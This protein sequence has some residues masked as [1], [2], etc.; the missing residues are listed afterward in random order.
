MTAAPARFLTALEHQPI[1]ITAEG[2]GGSL[3]PAEAESLA[4]I[5]ELRRGFCELGHRKLKLAQYC[6]VVSL[7]GRVLEV[8]PK[9]QGG[10]E[11]AE[12]CR[13][14]L[15][16][17]LKLTD[18]F[19]QFQHLPAGQHLR[20]APL[21]EAFISA[22]F[23]SV[24]SVL[25]GG[26]LRQYQEHEED[27]QIVR[28]RIVVGRQMGVHA[29][30]PDL[31][32]C[33][34]DELTADNVWNRVLKKAIRVT[35]PWIRSVELNRR[36]VELLGVLDEVND[37]HLAPLEVARLNFDRR[38]ERYRTA[39]DWA[40][41]ILALLTPALRAG[42]NEAPALLFDMNKLFESAVANTLRRQAG[43]DPGLQV[44]TQNSTH[45][46]ATVAAA[47][48]EGPSFALRP[49]LVLQRGSEVVAIADT[50]WKLLELDREG[51][52]VPSEADMYQM[53]AYATAFRCSELA[54]IYPRHD[55]ITAAVDTEFR[56]PPVNVNGTS[57]TV[58]VLGVDVDDDRLPLRMGD[59]SGLVGRLLLRHSS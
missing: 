15:L 30:R 48:R 58:R 26:L 41:W 14:V 12:Q 4:Q 38:A 29:N 1:P 31:V 9:T 52:Q 44:L 25:R 18:R 27:L 39:I 43:R 24:S 16:R 51:R 59:S 46:L 11:T 13:G 55:G 6:G 7:G 21:L 36:W 23:D 17:L 40:G 19:P 28:G 33:A 10:N 57:A 54:L 47:G 32:A 50:K 5:G 34:F 8:L 45:S 49:D 53:N 42:R 22:F 56:L 37:G 35:R 3:T 20:R 2:A